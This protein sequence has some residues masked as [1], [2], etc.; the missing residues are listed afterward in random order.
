MMRRCHVSIAAAAVAALVG[1]ATADVRINEVRGHHEFEDT[2]EYFE[3]AGKPGTP[4][5]ELTY[6]VLG[7]GV[8]SGTNDGSVE[9]VIGFVGLAIPGDGH[10]LAVESTFELPAEPDLVVE[11]NFEN[12]DNVTHLLVRGWTGALDQDLDVDDDG[13]LDVTPWTELVDVI[14]MIREHNPPAG[15]EFHYGPPCVGP[16]GLFVPGHAYRCEPGGDWL[17]GGFALGTDDTPGAAN[18][19]CD[20][21][22]CEGD[23]DGDGAVG[24]PDLVQL[25]ATWGPCCGCRADFDRDDL[26]GVEDLLVILAAWGPCP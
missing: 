18:G 5:D 8:S 6:V 25:L 15:T 12:N 24:V 23:A 13:T 20:P 3:L 14:A 7:D 26:V 2:S 1:V 11:L 9:A 16:E 10:F 22:T 21:A 19:G 4:L 17:I